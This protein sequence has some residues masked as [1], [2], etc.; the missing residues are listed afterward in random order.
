MSDGLS[1]NNLTL[2]E[3]LSSAVRGEKYELRGDENPGEIF[4]EACLQTVVPAVLAALPESAV[5]A[6]GFGALIERF[7]V[8]AFRNY[9]EVFEAHAAVDEMMTENGIAY[10][11]L[12]GCSS[13][14]YYPDPAMREMGDVDF[15]VRGDCVKKAKTIIEAAGYK[16]V[17]KNDPSHIAY[18]KEGCVR[19][20]LHFEPQGIPDGEAGRVI[21][22]YLSDISEKSERV[23]LDDISFVK[24]SDFHHLIVIL[25]HT[26]HHMLAEGVGLRHVF[27]V[28]FFISRFKDKF[29]ELFR[30]RLEKAGLWKFACGIYFVSQKYL[31]FPSYG[32]YN[33]FTNDFA[34]KFILDV[35]NGGNFGIK[36]SSRAMQGVMISD[37]GK[38]GV[39][40]GGEAAQGF[41]S[42]CAAARRRYPKLYKHVLLRPLAYVAFFFRTLFRVITGKRKVPEMRSAISEA[43]KRKELYKNFELFKKSDD[44][45]DKERL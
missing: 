19:L 24:P 4:K 1:K 21:K 3:I 9:S 30:E 26:Y 27:D 20:E 42:V 10:C 14:Y 5:K 36:D 12:K 39:S 44:N 28:A 35:L 34:E 25:M 23:T 40:D 45:G 33:D 18:E 17:D 29:G 6:Q 22:E 11:I 38:D 41:K 7:S 31:G 16:A 13:A 8:R 2:L 43:K 37:R 15:L 32:W